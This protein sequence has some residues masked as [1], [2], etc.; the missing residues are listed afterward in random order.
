MAAHGEMRPY[1]KVADSSADRI[2]QPP[3]WSFNP[4]SSL[5]RETLCC[6]L[7]AH[8]VGRLSCGDR[9]DRRQLCRSSL[10]WL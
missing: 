4:I 5:I 8:Y 7:I 3:P 2:V 9:S 6:I 1:R 10:V